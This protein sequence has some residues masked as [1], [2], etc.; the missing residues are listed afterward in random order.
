MFHVLYWAWLSAI[1]LVY[2]LLSLAICFWAGLYLIGLVYISL[3]MVNFIEL[4]FTFSCLYFIEPDNIMQANALL[5]QIVLYW[6]CLYYIESIHNTETH[7]RKKT[8]R[9][10]CKVQND[11]KR[12][13]S[14]YNDLSFSFRKF[15]FKLINIIN[16]LKPKKNCFRN[17]YFL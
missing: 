12:H 9:N 4:V 10:C 14:L 3:S 16:I 7:T 5:S 8:F 2:T 17:N 1:E 13:N 6:A 15:L 11:S